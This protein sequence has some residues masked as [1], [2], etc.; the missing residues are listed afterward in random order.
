LL[1]A[2]LEEW[3]EFGKASDLEALSQLVHAWSVIQYAVTDAEW[4]RT[5][6]RE[7]PPGPFPANW[8]LGWIVR[9]RQ[10]YWVKCLR[11]MLRLV[12]GS[13]P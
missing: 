8:Y 10:Y 2:Y 11:R 9:M 12:A 4:L 7:L 1:S 6:L 3:Q 13:N 5:Y